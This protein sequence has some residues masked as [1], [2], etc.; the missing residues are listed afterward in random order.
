MCVPNSAADAAS[1]DAG[2]ADADPT[3]FYTPGGVPS[4]FVACRPQR[5]RSPSQSGVPNF[6]TENAE[7]CAVCLRFLDPHDEGERIWC[8]ESFHARSAEIHHLQLL[9][10]LSRSQTCPSLR[11]RRHRQLSQHATT[12]M[13]RTFRLWMWCWNATREMRHGESRWAPRSFADPGSPTDAMQTPLWP[14]YKIQDDAG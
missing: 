12:K 13:R 14:Q 7:R 6:G 4:Q 1:A 8:T 10:L 11:L 3:D 5:S 2:S 9:R